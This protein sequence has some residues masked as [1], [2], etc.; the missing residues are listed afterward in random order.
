MCS[1]GRDQGNFAFELSAMN[2][3]IRF[4]LRALRAYLG[5]RPRLVVTFTDFEKRLPDGYLENSF[6]PWTTEGITNVGFRVDPQRSRARGYYTGFAFLLHVV[7]ASG[8][9]M[10]LLD[11]GSVDWT[12]KYLSNAKER[13]IIS[14]L[15]TE[16]LCQ[17]FAPI[18]AA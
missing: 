16:R 18:G 3:Q 10:E 13:L 7:R 17:E 4:H 12:Q 2:T 9:E 5:P 15:G 11:G 8:E 1:A 14:G 6:S